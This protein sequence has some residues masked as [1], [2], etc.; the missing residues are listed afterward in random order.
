MKTLYSVS[1]VKP[2]QLTTIAQC[3]CLQHLCRK[4]LVY[5]SSSHRADLKTGNTGTVHI[6]ASHTGKP[7]LLLVVMKAGCANVASLYI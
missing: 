1:T 7:I 2:N 4:H 5:T 6:R 3:H